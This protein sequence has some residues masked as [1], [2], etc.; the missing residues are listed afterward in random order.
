MNIRLLEFAPVIN[1]D[2]DELTE[3]G[4]P[5]RMADGSL[6]QTGPTNSLYWFVER[7]AP[8]F[9]QRWDIHYRR[10][11]AGFGY[12]LRI[13]H[14]TPATAARARELANT[15][16][17]ADVS[18]NGRALRGYQ[19]ESLRRLVWYRARGA[20]CTA[21][22]SD[23]GTG[24]TYVALALARELRLFPF[25]VC[26]KS[27]ILDWHEAAERIGVDCEAVNYEAL[28][29]RKCRFVVW[30]KGIP[31][32]RVTREKVLLIF[33]E[34]HACK[35]FD[36]GTLNVRLLASAAYAG[37]PL[38]LI[39]A[40]L[41]HSPAYL[42]APGFAL[43]LHDFLHFSTWAA[44]HGCFRA[45]KQYFFNNS[46][47]VLRKL[48]HHLFNTTAVRVSRAE[49]GS[50]IPDTQIIP[51]L[52]PYP[53]ELSARYERLMALLAE[54]KERGKNYQGK[55]AELVDELM[56][57]ELLKVASTAAL[58]LE[59]VEQGYSVAAFFN[60]NTPIDEFCRLSGCRAKI[61]GGQKIEER[62][63]CIRAF[64]R[65]EIPLIAVNNRAGSVGIGLHGRRDRATLVMPTFR[66]DVLR[67]VFGR[68][69][70][71]GGSKSVQFV[72][73]A[74]NSP[75]KKMYK[76]VRAKLDNIDI[77]NDGDTIGN[78]REFAPLLD[79]EIQ[80]SIDRTQL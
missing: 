18:V 22:L 14:A 64:R 65:D 24:K 38:H 69:S 34:A 47:T 32:W 2:P 52:T 54:Q 71:I 31:T 53:A 73:F 76:S 68:V 43:G 58:A 49:I 12:L 62:N 37:Y 1:L 35:S 70:R 29:S 17:P 42:Y 55:F 66:P 33:D 7:R 21:D 23:M 44:E 27:V 25:V 13:L 30:K 59:L 6:V 45:G 4:F 77:I 8:Q 51:K 67:Q 19:V 5:E 36:A 50:E 10:D 20:A 40:T 78:L 41:A 75:E 28:K 79:E 46:K 26:P 56:Q 11:A 72:L 61:R 39:S 48:H 60:F 57:I 74:D 15:P 80:Q 63:A 9:L 3:W 16:T